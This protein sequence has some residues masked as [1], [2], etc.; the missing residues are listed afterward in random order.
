MVLMNKKAMMKLAL[1]L[2][3]LGFTA[4]VVDARFGS[5]SFITQLLS[6]GDASNKACCDSC[7]CTRSI[8]PQCQCNDIGE[9]CHSACKACLCTRSLPPKCSCTDITDFCYKKCN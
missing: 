2:F 1:M 4:T 5:T 8:P 6:N 9:T 3:L 7:L